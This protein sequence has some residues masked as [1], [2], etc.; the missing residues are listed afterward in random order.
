MTAQLA[1]GQAKA[2]SIDLNTMLS[3][4]R[5]RL[6]YDRTLMAWTRT[7]M[8]LISFGFSIYKFFDLSG[9]KSP[10]AGALI[11]PRTYAMAMIL[12]GLFAL[13]L[14]VYDHRKSL[15]E[16]VSLGADTKTPPRVRR[17]AAAVA[18]LGLLAMAAVLLHE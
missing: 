6:S 18:L 2:P 9:L 14:A 12:I 4:K 17:V 7:S 5:T 15:L 3:F 1:V 11:G 10:A 13:L 16:L 8:S